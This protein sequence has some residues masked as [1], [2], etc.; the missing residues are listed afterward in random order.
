MRR[1]VTLRSV[2]STTGSSDRH[3]H[4]PETMMCFIFVAVLLAVAARAAAGDNAFAQRR[5]ILQAATPPVPQANDTMAIAALAA[6]QPLILM[7]RNTSLYSAELTTPVYIHN[8]GG[9]VIDWILQ[10]SFPNISAGPCLKIQKYNLKI[11]KYSLK[12]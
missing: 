3:F 1:Y 5:S 10:L 6:L 12:C 2:E 9:Q 8:V 7:L 11:Q 4:S